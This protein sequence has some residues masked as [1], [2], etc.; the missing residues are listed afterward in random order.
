[1]V[2]KL[3]AK[4]ILADNELELFKRLQNLKQ[5]D[6]AT[7]DY[8]EEFYKLTIQSRHR[9]LSKEKVSRY[10]KGLR[11]NIQDEIGMLKIDLVK[12]AY[13]YALREEDKLKRRHQ[14]NSRGKEKKEHS[15]KAKQIVV[16]EP[17]LFEHKKIIGRGEF[18]GTCFRCGEEAHR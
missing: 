17:K 12:D 1:M 4:F 16:E 6:M 9:E 13:Q 2:T 15:M 14:G 10:I 11:F 7:K 3:K 18:K 5:K 8:T